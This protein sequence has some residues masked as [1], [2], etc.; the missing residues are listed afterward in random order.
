MKQIL[1]NTGLSNLISELLIEYN[2][3]DI[4]ICP[5]SR[6]TPLTIS[7]I[8][9]KHF[10][11]TSTIDERAA[12][13][14][15]LGIAKSK[16]KPSVVLTTSGTAAA[17]L[18]PSIIEA[19]LSKTPIIVITADRPKSLLNSGENQTIKQNQLY[20]DFIRGSIHID[21]SDNE[22]IESIV[23]QLNNLIAKSIGTIGKKPPGPIHLNISFDEPLID[24]DC[25]YDIEIKKQ[26][27]NPYY[28]NFMLPKCKY[29][30][31]VCG[32]L[33]STNQTKL[34]IELAEKLNCPIL[35]D[36]LSQLRFNKKHPHI[37]SYYE[38]YIDKLSIKPD[39]IIRYGKKP[40][41]KKLNIFLKRYKNNQ[42][43][44]ISEYEKYN[45]DAHAITIK[46]IEGIET[47]NQHNK[48]LCN[49]ISGLE[50]QSKK[51]LKK[52]FV[53]EY[54]FEGNILYSTL[55][56]FKNND[57]LFIGNSLPIR[58]LE[59]YCPNIDKKI[60]VYSNRG[61]SGIDGQIAT[62]L[63]I[64]YIE[65]TKRNILILGDVSFFYDMNALLI[66]KQYNLNLN[67]I[68]I[69]NNGG[70]IFT[71]LPYNKHIDEDLKQYWTTPTD[72]DI[73][74]CAELYNG[75]YY[76]VKSIKEFENNLDKV[77]SKNGINIIEV[78]CD[79]K[80]TQKIEEQIKKEF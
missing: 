38:H 26:N 34:I 33:N 30:L 52:Y 70:Q 42:M 32:Q 25:S 66:A 6:N 62:S 27:S 79:F 13:F 18:L 65:K 36:P 50:E 16:H 56:H 17:N 47:L 60:M 7:F 78:K 12:G 31:I 77:L 15:T 23:N 39:Y 67:I 4:C 59:K 37:F 55:K 76:L 11:C 58:T 3:N 10:N 57:N 1:S 20:K 72:I 71:T 68:I 74:A 54:F 5:G 8:K 44:L 80:E 64:S 61:S 40:I 63:G 48:N 41:S 75:N 45:D 49:H 35:A 46:D 21:L 69:N 2:I 51:I 43:I 28:Q 73:K 24:N 53:N 9:N 29:P 22:S 19:D 14:F